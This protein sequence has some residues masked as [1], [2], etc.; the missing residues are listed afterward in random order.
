MLERWGEGPL[1]QGVRP[2]VI[3]FREK[4]DRNS[5]Y[6]ACREGL[7]KVNLVITEDS[8]YIS[9]ALKQ[10]HGCTGVAQHLKTF[11]FGQV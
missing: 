7:K 3:T 10:E 8:R 9:L 2:V 4:A 1:H 11:W 5:L 6:Q